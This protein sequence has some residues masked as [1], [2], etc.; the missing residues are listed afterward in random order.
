MSKVLLLIMLSILV[1]TVSGDEVLDRDHGIPGR[2]GDTAKTRIEID[3]LGCKTVKAI[4]SDE[5][6]EANWKKR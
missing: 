4:L 3:W 5:K 1:N 2:N 6:K